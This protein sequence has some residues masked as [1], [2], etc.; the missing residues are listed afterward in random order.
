MSRIKKALRIDQADWPS[1]WIGVMIV[2]VIVLIGMGFHYIATAPVPE[3]NYQRFHRVCAEQGGFVAQTK[4]GGLFE[5][6][7]IDC[8]KDN[9]ILYLPGFA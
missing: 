5:G 4:T 8:I 9:N 6:G 2:G 3:S 1:V 7:R